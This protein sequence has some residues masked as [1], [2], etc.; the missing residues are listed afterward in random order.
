MVQLNHYKMD[1]KTKTVL[2]FGIAIAA[3]VVVAIIVWYQVGVL[4]SD[5]YIPPALKASQA[6]AKASKTTAK[7][8]PAPTPTPSASK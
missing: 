2:Y 4:Q 5:Q 1:H 6:R 7:T 8:K 3:A